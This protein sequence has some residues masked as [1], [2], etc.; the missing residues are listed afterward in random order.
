MTAVTDVGTGS[1]ITFQSGLIAEILDVNWNGM[2]R[3][4]HET[5]HMGS[6][7]NAKTFVPGKLRDPGEIQV[8]INFDGDANYWLALIQAAETVTL[9][10]PIPS[11]DVSG[12]SLAASG[13]LTNVDVS[14]PMEDVMTATLTI[15][16]SGDVTQTDSSA[17]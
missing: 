17:V 5:S 13:F 6:A 7:N 14:D 11:G 10:F 12:P 3:S 16:L 4:S 15:K 8:E 9:T 1:T 2:A